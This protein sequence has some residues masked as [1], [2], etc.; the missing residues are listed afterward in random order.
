VKA[1]LA[2][3]LLAAPASAEELTLTAGGRQRWAL[4][5]EPAEGKGPRPLILLLHGGAGNPAQ[6]ERAYRL[7]EPA[8]AA[9]FL[10]AYPAGTGYFTRKRILT[11]NAG[12]CC[13]HAREKGVD[14]VAFLAALIERLVKDGRADPKA[15]FAAGMSNGAMMAHRLACERADLVAAI[16]PVAGTL[17]VPAC[18]PSRPVSVLLVHGTE[19]EHVPFAGGVGA[20]A[21][22]DVRSDR[23]VRESA[24]LWAAANGCGEKPGPVGEDGEVS[25]AGCAEGT[26]VRVLGHPGGHIWPGSNPDRYPGAD[27]M[28]DEPKTTAL[29][30]DFFK[31]HARR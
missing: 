8:L 28:L 13:G 23:S 20:K 27:P 31:T 4:L 2:L 10:V 14:D 17:A 18:K 11:W 29:I 3:L 22:G 5:R 21:R 25:W 9:G 12:N 30:L 26:D 7:T 15:V 19:D 16:A 24:G 1:L 6:A